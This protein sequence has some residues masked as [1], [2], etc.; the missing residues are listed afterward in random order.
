MSILEIVGQVVIV[1]GGLVFLSAA[2]GVIRFPDPYTRTSAVGTAGGI[3]IVL[4]TVGC[5]LVHPSV[6]DTIKVIAIVVLQL[7]TSA[8][9]SIA[10]ARSA[11]ITHTPMYGPAFTDLE[12]E[13]AGEHV[14][15]EW[16]AGIE[17][18]GDSSEGRPD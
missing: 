6:S 12:W 2:L 5:L 7:A 8:V 11:F 4:V 1:L 3:G 16:G 18:G 10:I 17:P 13:E 9:G 15:D 14:A